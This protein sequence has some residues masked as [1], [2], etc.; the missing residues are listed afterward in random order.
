M[1]SQEHR[2]RDRKDFDHVFKRGRSLS[3]AG[4]GLKYART[5]LPQ[6]RFAFVVGVKV[7]KRAVKRNTLRRRMRAGVS[8]LMERVRPGFDVM[9]IAR[10]EALKF[11]YATVRNAMGTLLAKAG[12]LL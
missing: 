12:L 9:L 5:D 7:S 6:S 8:E 1:L 10:P 2:L 4:F 11:D 3:A